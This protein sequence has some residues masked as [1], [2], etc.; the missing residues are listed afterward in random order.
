MLLAHAS[1]A[2]LYQQRYKASQGGQISFTTLVTWPE[3][4][5]G[6]AEASRA[7]QNMLDSEVGWL[8]DPIYFGDYPGGWVACWLVLLLLLLSC[9]C[10]AMCNQEKGSLQSCCLFHDYSRQCCAC[11]TTHASTGCMCSVREGSQKPV[12]PL[13]QSS[14]S[15]SGD[16]WT[17]SL[18]IGTADISSASPKSTACC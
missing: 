2:K 18:S 1:A 16:H 13:Q 4:V 6:S 11:L 15:C 14:G 10:V 5:S 17:S 9:S 7:A 8:L 12:P 3:P